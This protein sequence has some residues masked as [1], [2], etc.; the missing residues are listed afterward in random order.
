[1]A[2]TPFNGDRRRAAPPRKNSPRRPGH[3]PQRIPVPAKRAIMGCGV[4]VDGRRVPDQH[5]YKTALKYVRELGKGFVWIG[6]FEPDAQQMADIASYFG[7]HEL[8]VE[9]ATVGM[10]RPKLETYDDALVLNMRTVDYQPHDSVQD[11]KEIVATG[12]ILV[13][14]ARDFVM[15]VRH[16]N[17]GALVGLRQQMESRP[18]FLA[19]GPSAVTHAVTDHVVDAYT[20]VTEAVEKDVEELESAVFNPTEDLE[21][22]HIYLLKR[23]V[24][25]LKHT[26]TPLALPLRR[27]SLD[28]YQAICGDIRH[29]F[30]DVYDHQTVVSEAVTAYD[31]RLTSLVSAAIARSGNQQNQDMRRI[32]AWVAIVA[33]PTMIAGIYGMNFTNMPELDTKY[34]YYGALGAMLGISVVLFV[35]FRRNKWL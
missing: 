31:E 7:L 20:T 9:D 29:Y 22:D 34:G 5:D 3:D 4:Y 15:T 27:L 11:A 13:I 19:L 33:V 32:S 24:L 10:Q 12:D 28:H 30:R 1:M 21:I 16:G 8:I 17:F 23:E 25:E 6:I 26:V 35:L 2:V 14:T 18:E